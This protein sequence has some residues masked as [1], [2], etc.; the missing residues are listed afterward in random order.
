MAPE[1]RR[2]RLIEAA[3]ALLSGAEGGRLNAV[4][5]NK[6]LFYL[7]LASLRDFGHPF[8]YATFLALHQGPVVAKYKTRLIQALADEDIA[9]QEQEADSKP[10]RLKNVPASF[11]YIAAGTLALAERIGK[12]FSEKT[13]SSA[14]DFSHQNPGWKLA[15]DDGLGV[16]KQPTRINPFIAMQQILDDDP[17]LHADH[18]LDRAAIEAADR[19]EGVPW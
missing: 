13:S 18:K 6:A 5:L 19:S 17:W 15:Y 9:V 14:S 3:A 2:A 7:D 4:N 1:E 16:G 8:S 12:W 11:H 10:I